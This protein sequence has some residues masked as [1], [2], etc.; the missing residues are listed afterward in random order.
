MARRSLLRLIDANANRALEGARVCEEIIRF[1]L[2][3]TR[4]FR[5]IRALRHKIACA[6]NQLHIPRAEVLAARASRYDIGRRAT[7]SSV[8][9]LEQLLVINFQRLKE[10]L[11][12]LE[13]CSRVLAPRKS[14]LFQQLRFR[15]YG[16]ERDTLLCVATLRRR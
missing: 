7:A 14:E 6:L 11:R 8:E 12:A 1:H 16:V 10:S 13:E 2:E 15:A 4:E 5:K 9:S 3:A